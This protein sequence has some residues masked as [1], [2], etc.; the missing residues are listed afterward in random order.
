MTIIDPLSMI[1]MAQK[2]EEQIKGFFDRLDNAVEI[3]E[4]TSALWKQI[5]ENAVVDRQN[6]YRLYADLWNTLKNDPTGHTMNG[7]QAAKYIERMSKANDQLM[8]LGQMMNDFEQQSE[9]IDEND[10]FA[11]I[12]KDENVRS[13]N[14]AK[15]KA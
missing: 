9:E 1:E 15:E 4:K 7:N 8:Q 13:I 12:N 5:Y 2:T 14:S 10:V 11:Q 3:D 6:A